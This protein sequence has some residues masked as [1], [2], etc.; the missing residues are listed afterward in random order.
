MVSKAVAR[1]PEQAWTFPL[2]YW[3]GAELRLRGDIV[4]EQPS[5]QSLPLAFYFFIAVP[6]FPPPHPQVITHVSETLDRRLLLACSGIS[7]PDVVRM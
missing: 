1:R 2:I 5:L 6:P 3:L 4:F 7:S